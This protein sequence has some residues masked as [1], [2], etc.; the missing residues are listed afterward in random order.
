MWRD[1]KGRRS[2]QGERPGA[3]GKTRREGASLFWDAKLMD[4]LNS[5]CRGTGLAA[6]GRGQPETVQ[7]PAPCQ[8]ALTHLHPGQKSTLPLLCFPAPGSQHGALPV[9][10]AF[11]NRELTAGLKASE[12]V[13][14]HQPI[15]R[16]V[17][18]GKTERQL[19]WAEMKQ[20]HSFIACLPCAETT[21]PTSMR[22][23][24]SG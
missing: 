24:A 13:P 21:S 1:G 16:E 9:G 14:T 23:S 20:H 19:P 18:Q 15:C 4:S 8:L 6:G 3:A 11:G 22:V 12:E 2:Q 7:M 10:L 17:P 5:Q